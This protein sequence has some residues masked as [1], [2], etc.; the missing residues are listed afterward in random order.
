MSSERG[1]G[2]VGIL[3]AL[4]GVLASYMASIHGT[5][6]DQQGLV[7]FGVWGLAAVLVAFIVDMLFKY[8]LI[9]AV[10]LVAALG[11]TQNPAFENAAGQAKALRATLCDMVAYD[12]PDVPIKDWL[13]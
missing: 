3:L 4:L 9:L 6:L 2:P 5:E 12:N 11:W 10:L 13:C 1:L 8:V 7:A